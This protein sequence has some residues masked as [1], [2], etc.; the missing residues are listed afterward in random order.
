MLW[1]TTSHGLYG[2]SLTDH[3]ALVNAEKEDFVRKEG[4]DE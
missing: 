3:C 1:D 4:G 2:T